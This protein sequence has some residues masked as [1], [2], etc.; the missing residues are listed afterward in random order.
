VISAQ[1]KR[2]LNTA[3]VKGADEVLAKPFENEDLLTIVDNWF[4]R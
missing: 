4:G 3:I 2:D 1:D